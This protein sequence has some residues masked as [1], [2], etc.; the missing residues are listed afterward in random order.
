[1]KEDLERENAELRRQVALL[2]AAKA[3]ADHEIRKSDLRLTL[4]LLNLVNQRGIC[5]VMRREGLDW[6]FLSKEE[7][8]QRTHDDAHLANVLKPSFSKKRAA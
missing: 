5:A 3:E 8:R 2:E 1:M 4:L 6:E 7:F